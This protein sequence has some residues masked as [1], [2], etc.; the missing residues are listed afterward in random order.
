MMISIRSSKQKKY[1]RVRNPIVVFRQKHSLLLLIFV[2]RTHVL[3]SFIAP[4]YRTNRVNR[5]INTAF[6]RFYS[7]PA[8]IFCSHHEN[9]NTSFFA[10]HTKTSRKEIPGKTRKLQSRRVLLLIANRRTGIKLSY[11]LKWYLYYTFIGRF[12]SFTLIHRITWIRLLHIRRKKERKTQKNSLTS[13]RRKIYK[14][15]KKKINQDGTRRW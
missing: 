2:T 15:K 5:Y 10:A 1:R 13:T 3:R 6:T 8:L 7:N 14:N 9:R 11:W 4:V 12:D